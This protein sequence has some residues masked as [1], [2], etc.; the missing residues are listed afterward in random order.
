MSFS[1]L[2]LSEI[3]RLF[4]V[5]YAHRGNVTETLADLTNPR[6]K[7]QGVPKTT[8]D[9]WRGETAF[10][11]ALEQLAL[12]SSWV[13]TH[14]WRPWMLALDDELL[15]LRATG[16]VTVKD[17]DG[18]ARPWSG[19]SD[20]KREQLLQEHDMLAKNDNKQDMFT[21]FMKGVF[22]KMTPAL[23]VPQPHITVASTSVIDV[24]VQETEP[25]G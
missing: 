10:R 25:H 11:F 3:Q 21:E 5:K 20:K 16:V 18:R 13:H 17:K 1:Y 24:P 8:Y 23:P 19:L 9:S 6:N 12:D 2:D 15:L 7:Q 4:L 14:V 22:A